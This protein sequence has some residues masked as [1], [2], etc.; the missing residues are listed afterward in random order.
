MCR[1]EAKQLDQICQRR[2]GLTR[3]AGSTTTAVRLVLERLAHRAKVSVVISTTGGVHAAH[4][5]EGGADLQVVQELLGHVNLTTTML[6]TRF[7]NA[8]LKK[9][10]TRCHPRAGGDEYGE[11]S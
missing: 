9:I 6:Y 3:Q 7:S 11:E 2:A 10:H 5:L 1:E 4:L 8:D